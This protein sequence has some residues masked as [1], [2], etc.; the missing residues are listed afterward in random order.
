MTATMDRAARSLREPAC[1]AELVWPEGL[2]AEVDDQRRKLHEL[3]DRQGLL[4][5]WQ[6]IRLAHGRR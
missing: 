1:S 3:N 6:A 4:L 2:S 5:L